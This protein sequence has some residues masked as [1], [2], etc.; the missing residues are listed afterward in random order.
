M[1]ARWLFLPVGGAWIA[2]APVLRWN[3][4]PSLNRPID[5][6]RTLRGRRLFGDNKSWRGALVMGGG[7]F[8]ATLAAH[9]SAWYR[10]RVPPP[11]GEVSPRLLG[12]LLAVGTVAGEL[13]NSLMK[14]Q[15]DIGPGTQRGTA[16]GLAL[17]VLDQGDF[18]LAIW[19]LLA[20]VW[21][22]PARQALDAFAT[23]A[24]VHSGVNVVGYAIGARTSPI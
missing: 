20:P 1:H 11:L 22:M 16:A 7:V 9:R 5:G 19:L 13:P 3:L 23:V 15:L 24:A 18:V 21:R 8:A 2:H 6:G 12:A 14:R 17:T 10:E 4:A